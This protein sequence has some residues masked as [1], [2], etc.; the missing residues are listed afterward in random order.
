MQVLTGIDITADMLGSG[1]SI[2][3]PAPGE[4][5]WASSTQYN[6]G[7]EVILVSTHRKYKCAADHESTP[8]TRPDLSPDKWVDIGPTMR[9]APFDMYV[10]TAATAM[11][12]VVYEINPMRYADSIMLFGLNG[13]G[14]KVEALGTDFVYEADL[15]EEPDGWFEYFFLLPR[16]VD[17]VV[18]SNIPFTG[19]NT[20]RITVSAEDAEVSI[21]M[22][23]VGE[24][25]DLMPSVSELGETGGVTYGAVAEPASYSYIKTEEDGSTRIVRR[26]SATN[27]RCTA[28]LPHT[29]ADR[30]SRILHDLLDRPS[31][32]IPSR[33][34][35]YKA[36]NI[37]GLLSSAPVTYQSKGFV[38]IE[39]DVRGMI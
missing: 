4:A 16:I 27:L 37:Y 17:R 6:V 29:D 9:F 10:S 24:M 14:C 20:Y 7:A 33:A 3:E 12:Q 2:P 22:I 38:T 1:T 35:G 8:E 11:D 25:I 21:G 26:H 5:V 34:A 30:A 19:N 31:A 13:V 23:L 32:W 39:F 36:L 15:V 18:L 28:V